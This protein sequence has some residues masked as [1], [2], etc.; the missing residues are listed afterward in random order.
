MANLSDDLSFPFYVASRLFSQAYREPLAEIGLT[1]PQYL[2]MLVLW[3]KDGQMVSEI[4][5]KLQLDSG[6]LTPLLKRLEAAHLIKRV[7]SE[8]DERRVEIELTYPGSA[9]QSKA[10]KV[11][12]KADEFFNNWEEKDVSQ[13]KVLMEKL[14]AEFNPA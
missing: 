7:R 9:L 3:E 2:V 10:A 1:Y 6:T 13:L 12:E 11:A 5:Q 4:G 14:I 8:E